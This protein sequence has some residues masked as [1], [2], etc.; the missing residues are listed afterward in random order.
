MKKTC[1]WCNKEYITDQ[2]VQ[3]FCSRDCCSKWRKGRRLSPQSEFK[4]G[5]KPWHA[6]KPLP[7]YYKESLAL[8]KRKNPIKYWLNKKRESMRG[9][10]NWNWK[11]GGCRYF[12]HKEMG[13]VEY[14]EWRR[15]IFKR[16]NYTCQLCGE[17]AGALNAHHLKLWKNHPKLRY[18]VK[19][20]ITLCEKCHK[21]VHRKVMKIYKS[22]GDR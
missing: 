5:N 4:K 6:G 11:G 13:R 17:Y 8:A 3:K 2:K 22:R 19:N 1:K 21:K 12:R 10:K 16:D 9:E 14:I 15:K 20:G 18:S 7:D